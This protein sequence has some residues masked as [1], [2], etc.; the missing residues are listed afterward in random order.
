MEEQ[1][2][3][4]AQQLA[5]VK[6]KLNGASQTVQLDK[7]IGQVSTPSCM[8]YSF[9]QA[10][11]EGPN[12][13]RGYLPSQTNKGS[14]EN[15]LYAPS[16]IVWRVRGG[17]EMLCLEHRGAVVQLLHIHPRALR[18]MHRSCTCMPCNECHCTIRPTQPLASRGCEHNSQL[19]AKA[20]P[21]STLTL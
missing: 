4:L 17:E 12:A 3:G 1:N 6:H 8:V 14:T 20:S 2:Q 7:D 5:E 11:V 10:D 13:P 21:D 19:V 9:G 16:A 15:P 18:V